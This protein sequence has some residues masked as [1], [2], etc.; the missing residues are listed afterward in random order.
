MKSLAA[1][2]LVCVMAAGAQAVI[3]EDFSGD[4][5]GWT[6]TVILDNVNT[7]VQN[8]AA[9]Q[10]VDGALQLNTTVRDG[11]SVE[12]YA[13]IISGVSLGVGE[14]LQ[15][16]ITHNGGSQ[17]I[18]LYVGG[19]TPTFNV[20]QDYVAMYGRG[21]QLFSRGF[22]GTTEYGLVGN[23]DSNVYDKLF[24]KNIDGASFETGWYNGATR[25]VM[26]TRTPGYANAA[27]VIGIYADT[28]GTGILGSVDNLQIVPEPA[29]MALLGIGGL[30]LSKRRR[31]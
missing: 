2:L 15:I 13:M 8:T 23:W 11:S 27:T 26:A 29:T 7:A 25:N 14:E 21:G 5:S 18:G 31:V 1:V 10:I 20:R 6:S 16:D 24:I 22:D 30:F 28:R 19:T 12:Q 3:I 17:D 9:W 4:L